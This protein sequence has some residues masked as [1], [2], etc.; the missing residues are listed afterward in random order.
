MS[1]RQGWTKCPECGIFVKNIRKHKARNRCSVQH[2]RKP[3]RRIQLLVKKG[4][5]L[6]GEKYIP[7]SFH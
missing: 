1:A 7:P 4:K 5:L 6:L 2:I 3:E